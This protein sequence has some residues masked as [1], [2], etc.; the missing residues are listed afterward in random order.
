MTLLCKEKNSVSNRPKAALV[1]L[2]S[3]AR[4]QHRHHSHKEIV[5]KLSN[6]VDV[7]SFRKKRDQKSSDY[8]IAFVEGSVCTADHV[9]ELDA[10][11]RQAR[12]V[13]ALGTCACVGGVHQL[14]NPSASSL[15]SHLP[16][17]PIDE[18]IKVDGKIEGCPVARRDIENMVSTLLLRADRGS[19]LYS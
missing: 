10:I 5:A 11:R 19:D 4:C 12:T 14:S 15:T 18:L 13:I 17:Q 3:C 9:V 8:E 2:S 7:V 6:L 16:T 1:R